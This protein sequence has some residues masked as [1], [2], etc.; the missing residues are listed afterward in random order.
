MRREELQTKIGNKLNFFMS[1]TGIYKT[2]QDIAQIAEDYATARELAVRKE[3]DFF[4]EE[5]DTYEE[6]EEGSRCPECLSQVT[7]NELEMFGGLCESCSLE[8]GEG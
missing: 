5:K 4:G 7:N 6:L 8:G 2:I 3:L 1:G